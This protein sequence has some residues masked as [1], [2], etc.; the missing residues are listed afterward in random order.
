MH[1][2]ISSN[3]SKRTSPYLR[4]CASDICY[5]SQEKQVKESGEGFTL[6]GKALDP[7][8]AA[9]RAYGLGEGTC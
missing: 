8:S 2:N 4:R 5:R 6:S 1:R 3:Y 7:N 9:A